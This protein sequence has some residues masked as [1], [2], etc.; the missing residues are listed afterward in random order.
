MFSLKAWLCFS[1]QYAEAT[2]LKSME[3][4]P[5]D[6]AIQADACGIL[7][8]AALQSEEARAVIKQSGCIDA[9]F[10][11]QLKHRTHLRAQY[12]V[13]WFHH[14]LLHDQQIEAEMA[15]GGGHHILGIMT[16]GIVLP[17]HRQAE[18]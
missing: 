18:D 12:N 8:H 9:V 2:T 6:T 3:C 7:A 14:S 16:L 4:H 15:F 10:Q 1:T 5:E 13:L 17:D 11:C